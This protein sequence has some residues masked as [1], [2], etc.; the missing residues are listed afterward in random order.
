MYSILC[1][2]DI[3]IKHGDEIVAKVENDKIVLNSNEIIL[4]VYKEADDEYAYKHIILPEGYTLEINGFDEGTMTF[5]KTVVENGKAKMISNVSDV[6]VQKGSSYKEIIENGV[7][8]ALEYDKENDGISDGTLTCV[9]IDP[10]H[11]ITDILLGDIDGDGA[12]NSSD[13]SLV[14]R[15][16][17]LIATGEAPTFS[18]AQNTAA[19]VNGDNAVDSSDASVILAYYAYTSTGGTG[20]ISEFMN[21]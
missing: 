16:Y 21:K 7:T 13:A 10:E 5:E 14:L 9:M 8:V 19:D 2:I 12:V 11:A 17:A 6:P 3:T 20:N 1:P 18:E 4:N 15:E